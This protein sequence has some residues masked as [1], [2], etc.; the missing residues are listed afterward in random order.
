MHTAGL[1]P[2][3]HPRIHQGCSTS[4]HTCTKGP[5][6]PGGYFAAADSDVE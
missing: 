3:P 4:W 6:G 5:E 2:A 1:E